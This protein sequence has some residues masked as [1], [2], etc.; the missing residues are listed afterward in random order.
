[1]MV[2]RRRGGAGGPYSKAQFRWMYA[3]HQRFAH[4]WG[5]RLERRGGVK[6]GYRALPVR[7]GVRKRA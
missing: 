3:T 4:K 2:A 1:M 6:T 5:E 7:K